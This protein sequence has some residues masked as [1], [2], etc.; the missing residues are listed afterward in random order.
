MEN[1]N[2]VNIGV[3]QECLG[4]RRLT[5]KECY[6]A[7]AKEVGDWRKALMSAKTEAAVENELNK[8]KE[9]MEKNSKNQ[10]L[11][12][13][14][15]WTLDIAGSINAVRMH[16]STRSSIDDMLKMLLETI[17]E[18]LQEENKKEEEKARKLRNLFL[19]LAENAEQIAKFVDIEN[20]W[21]ISRLLNSLTSKTSDW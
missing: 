18:I 7:F 11:N 10:Q 20:I 2:K 17:E 4:V 13:V 19:R 6:E 3:K 12:D 9:L 5:R 21:L 8:I 16:D 1:E 14:E 15:G